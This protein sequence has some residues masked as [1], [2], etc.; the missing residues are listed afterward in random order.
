MLG[1]F[2][3]FMGAIAIVA[4]EITFRLQR[5]QDG[6]PKTLL[7]RL[8]SE[9]GLEVFDAAARNT[10]V[11]AEKFGIRAPK[12]VAIDADHLSVG[13]HYSLFSR[14]PLFIFGKKSLMFNQEELTGA[15]AYLAAHF[16][17]RYHIFN[18][19]IY[20]F[21]IFG[22]MR[23]LNDEIAADALAASRVGCEPVLACLR[24]RVA[25]LVKGGAEY[26]E[27]AE[28]QMA[29]IKQLEKTFLTARRLP[30]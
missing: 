14:T 1:A 5:E 18:L 10:H 28:E 19:F 9:C 24:K 30:S 8:D 22:I 15:M 13:L 23:S 7:Q 21:D 27:A 26:E 16:K 29:R 25:D 4:R 17:R 6:D 2:F 12:I 20:F 11:I 3:I